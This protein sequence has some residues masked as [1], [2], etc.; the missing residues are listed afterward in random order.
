[1]GSVNAVDTANAIARET[2]V[3]SLR[4][5]APIEV[6]R[7]SLMVRVTHWIN[8]AAF[9]ILIP[10]GALIFWAH[11]E[12]YWGETGY[13]GEPAW[14]HLPITPQ[15]FGS[16]IGRAFH[17]FAAWTL[18]LNGAVYLSWGLCSNHFRKKITPSRAQLGWR[19]ILHE[20]LQHVR[21]RHATGVAALEYNVLQKFA[22]I[23]V[24][25]VLVPLMLISG[26]TM[27][28]GFTAA[29]PELFLLWGRQTARS[30]H[31]IS[32]SL[33]TMFLVVHLFQV[34]IIGVRNEMRSMLTGRFVLPEKS[35]TP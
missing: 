32:A 14:L 1:M 30:V 21:L 10:S 18:V 12:L 15:P 6:Y 9:L 5:P 4:S 22:Y 19:H 7:H 34:F 20:I 3:P 26:L 25:F 17:F 16:L 24:I 29:V 35:E 27:S 28:P 33:L 31:F 13:F 2:N 8:A 23:V 11:P